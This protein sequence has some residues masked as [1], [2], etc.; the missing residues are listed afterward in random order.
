MG[1]RRARKAKQGGI[2][3]GGRVGENKRNPYKQ[4]E[5]TASQGDE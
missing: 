5:I 3:P 1:K 4:G 2:A